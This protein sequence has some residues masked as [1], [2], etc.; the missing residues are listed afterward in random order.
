M[1]ALGLAAVGAALVLAL[2]DA[3]E[4]TGLL[5]RWFGWNALRGLGARALETLTAAPLLVALLAVGGT[6]IAAAALSRK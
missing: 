2:A 5:A 1:L 3:F 6:L 4:R